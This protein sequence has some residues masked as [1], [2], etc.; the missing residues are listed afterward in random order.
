M[1][2]SRVNRLSV[3]GTV[4][5]FWISMSLPS[6]VT[7]LVISEIYYNPPAGD[8]SLEFIEIAND[9]SMPEDLSGYAFVNGVR[10]LFP[11]GTILPSR[12]IVVVCA[13][14]DA[15]QARYGIDNTIG[16]FEGRLDARGERLTLVNHVG[17][18]VQ[19]IR[20][21]D[22]GKWP[23]GPD[24]AGHSLV[25]ESVYL[26]SGEPE[27][28]TRSPKL[29]GSPGR[30][31]F[32]D[33]RELRFDET[34]IL[35]TGA[36]WRF[37]QGTAP[38]SE[39]TLRWTEADHDDG[40][41]AVGPSGFGFGDDDDMTLL[42]DM[43]G[44]YTSVALRKRFELPGSQLTAPGDFFLGVDYDDGFCAF[45]N[46]AEIARAN[47][48]EEVTWDQR[49]TGSREA[50]EEQ[51]FPV[52]RQLLR[53]GENVIA[54]AGFNRSL[55]NSD[56]SLIPRLVHRHFLE[57]ESPVEFRGFFNELYRG[58][59]AGTGWVELFNPAG[60]SRD[61]SGLT[62]SDDPDRSDRYIFPAGTTI[63]PG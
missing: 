9:S 18:V 60:R 31:N 37:R 27:S 7:A 48:P 52:D 17:I 58:A 24:G 30:R 57:E 28:W 4:L 55:G 53:E 56:F 21:R 49:A 63:A 3:R 54:V 20:Y 43:K 61:L 19:N 40:D 38:F 15:V 41:W 36:E 23:V 6:P 26:D 22:R 44:N 29:G 2:T 35:D 5:L 16:N 45:L 47:C 33:A 1:F 25:L 13:D 14:A 11:P 51:L 12:G 34:V 59:E 50:G 42:D 32:P 39:P 46:G 62:I 10:F 8:E